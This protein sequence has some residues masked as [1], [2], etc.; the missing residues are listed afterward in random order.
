MKREVDGK[1][2]DTE[3]STFVTNWQESY[4]QEERV[5]EAVIVYKTDFEELFE[6]HIEKHP[7]G[8]IVEN[9]ITVK[10]QGMCTGCSQ[11][12][13]DFCTCSTELRKFRTKLIRDSRAKMFSSEVLPKVQKICKVEY[14]ESNDKYR[15]F[16]TQNG[17]IDY[18]PKSDRAYLFDEKRWTDEGLLSVEK[19][20]GLWA[21]TPKKQRSFNNEKCKIDFGKYKGKNITELTSEEELR[22][23]YWIVNTL[24]RNFSEEDK[25]CNKKY[26]AF[27]HHLKKHG[28]L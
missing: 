7:N 22:Y 20:T 12:E 28:K 16:S 14:T 26:N 23:C 11:K 24:W 8:V 3:N 15:I 5:E 1:I 27:L 6:H 2:Y 9:I 17:I 10:E 21:P 19:S 13:K 25:K 18:Y 4:G